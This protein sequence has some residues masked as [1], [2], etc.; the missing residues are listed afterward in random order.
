MSDRKTPDQKRDD[1]RQ[2]I[3]PDCDK[4]TWCRKDEKGFITVPRLLPWIT[5]DPT[6]TTANPLVEIYR[7]K[8]RDS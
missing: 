5:L 7:L 4:F 6:S 3:W 8:E 1:L 2:K